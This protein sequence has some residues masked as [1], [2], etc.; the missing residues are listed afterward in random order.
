MKPITRLLGAEVKVLDEDEGLVRYIASDETIDS[1]G[2]I[3][4]ASGWRF[5]RFKKNAPFVDSHRYDTVERLLGK[6]VDFEVKNGKL[7]ETVQ[8]AKD[9]HRLAETGW[10]LTV[11]GFLKCVSVG[12]R[13]LKAIWRGDQENARAWRAQ[14][15]QLGLEEDA[16]VSRIFLQQEQLELSAVIVPANPNAVMMS[17][18]KAYKDGC[19]EDGDI[20]FLTREFAKQRQRASASAGAGDAD[21]ANLLRH[22]KW[23]E[24]I[25]ETTISKI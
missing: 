1:D 6:V 22:C 9:A 20:E 23:F 16:P 13:P 8:W 14:L 11:G 5:N 17:L 7:I 4:R 10:K 3:I 18:G 19:I 15:R 12:F 2:E 25:L 24:Q 21:E